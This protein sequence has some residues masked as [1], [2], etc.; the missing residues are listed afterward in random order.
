MLNRVLVPLCMLI[1]TSFAFAAEKQAMP[2]TKVYDMPIEKVYAAVVQVASRDYNV[3]SAV[4]DG[5][6]VTFFEGGTYPYVFSAICR[7]AEPNK[8]LVAITV[9]QSVGNPQVFGV[10]KA[11]EKQASRFW[12]ELDRAI[13]INQALKPESAEAGNSRPSVKDESAR[14]TVKSNPDGADITVDGKFVG[15]T[16]STVEIKPGDHSVRVEFSGYVPWER[17]LS[18]SSGDQTSLNAILQQKSP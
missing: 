2:L 10:G 13:Q 4:K 1:C 17:R 7:E 14:L 9:E 11:K 6:S 12:A 5:Y 3:K 16:P 15:S 18:M 8:T